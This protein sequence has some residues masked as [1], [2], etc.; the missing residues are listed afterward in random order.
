MALRFRVP[1]DPNVLA[2]PAFA[3]AMAVGLRGQRRRSAMRGPTNGDY[4]WRDTLAS[5]TMGTASLVAPLV[6]PRLLKP[7]GI[8]RQAPLGRATRRW[9]RHGPGV[10]GRKGRHRR[11]GWCHRLGDMGRV[12]L[13]LVIL[14]TPSLRAAREGSPGRR[15]RG[16][17]LGLPVL[18][19][20]SP[21]AREPVP[22]GGPRDASFERALQPVHRPVG[23]PALPVLDPH[24]ADRS[25]GSPGGNRQLAVASSGAPQI[26]LPVHRPQLREH[27]DRLGSPVRDVRTR[28]R[29]GGVRA[30]PQPRHLQ[31]RTDRL[32]RARPAPPR[33]RQLDQLGGAHVHRVQRPG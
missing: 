21:V 8:G 32:P 29:T 24:R 6:V 22:L 1:K 16:G 19:E 10:C 20:P 17:R 12:D 13:G 28:G 33:H 11:D 7:F 26:E 2:T 18:L 3:V 23:Q 5:L 14:A 27:P 25:P 30:D 15:R 9:L 4:E 31:P